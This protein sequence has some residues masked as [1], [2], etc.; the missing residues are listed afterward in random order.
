MA[1]GLS[2]ATPSP[3]GNV[4]RCSSALLNKK[5]SVS[6]ETQAHVDESLQT[7]TLKGQTVNILGL[8]DHIVS[9]AT[10]HLC[11]CSEKSDTGNM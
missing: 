7:F 11:P 9:I 1:S 10:I 4:R 2:V 5:K 6:G 8:M 3:A